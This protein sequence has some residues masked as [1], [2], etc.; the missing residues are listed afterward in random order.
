MSEQLI[1][2]TKEK[3]SV[4]ARKDFDLS[5]WKIKHYFSLL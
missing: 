3:F 1:H 2:D 5:V 4:H